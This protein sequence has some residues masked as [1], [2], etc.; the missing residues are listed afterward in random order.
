MTQVHVALE[1]SKLS[2]SK[3]AQ[4]IMLFLSMALISLTVVV[5][6]TASAIIPLIA[7]LSL[8]FLWEHHKLNQIKINAL[9]LVY[10]L[11]FLLFAFA[12]AFWSVNFKG[13]VGISFK[14]TAYLTIGILLYST[15]MIS[16]LKKWVGYIA[17]GFTLA[18]ALHIFFAIDGGAL[19]QFLRPSRPISHTHLS[20]AFLLFLLWPLMSFYAQSHKKWVYLF[21]PSLVF[22]SYIRD[23]HTTKVA[24]PLALLSWFLCLMAPRFFL[25]ALAILSAIVIVSFP[26]IV[27]SI[28]YQEIVENY[29]PLVVKP[30]YHHRIA[31]LKRAGKLVEQSP[32]IGQGLK[33]YQLTDHKDDYIEKYGY[34]LGEIQTKPL[35]P[36]ELE[37]MGRSSHP[38]NAIMEIWYELGAVGIILLV[39]FLVRS[40]WFISSAG[41]SRFQL[42]TFAGLYVSSFIVANNIFGIWQSWLLVLV[43]AFSLQL[44]IMKKSKQEQTTN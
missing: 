44:S 1:N 32:Y 37:K 21:I 33:A 42:A 31:I 35:T 20:L 14:L 22:I 23:F 17:I 19:Y 25:R 13:A 18:L 30:S 5:P 2:F 3:G 41:Y 12:S 15:M 7:V 26:W 8:S 29:K 38:H 28:S 27:N 16:S 10:L 6:N 36:E 9:S 39:F 11:P 4:S 24:L 34:R 40:L 43:F